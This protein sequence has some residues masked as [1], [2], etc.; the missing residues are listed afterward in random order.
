MIARK[1]PPSFILVDKATGE[2]VYTKRATGVGSEAIS[3]CVER[4]RALA[5]QTGRIYFV[6]LDIMGAR[7]GMKISVPMAYSLGITEEVGPYKGRTM[8]SGIKCCS[9]PDVGPSGQGMQCYNCRRWEADNYLKNPGRIRTNVFACYHCGKQIRGKVVHSSDGRYAFHGNCYMISERKAGRELH[10]KVRRNVYTFNNPVSGPADPTAARE[11]ELYI[12]NDSQLYHS[13]FVPIV[14]NLMLK[15]R[16]GVYNRELAAKLFMYLMDAGAKKYVREFGTGGKIDTMFNKNTRM[17]AARA[18]R[19]SFETEAELGNYDRMIG[20]VS[21]PRGRVRKNIY[22]FNNP[23]KY[24]KYGQRSQMERAAG[25]V[26]LYVTTWAPGDGMTRYRFHRKPADY[27][28]G[29]GIYTANGRGEAM[30]FIQSYGIGRSR[31]N[32]LNQSEIEQMR[33]REKFYIGRSQKYERDGQTADAAHFR[34]AS[35]ESRNIRERH[36]AKGTDWWPNPCKNPVCKNPKHKHVRKNPLLQ[37]I[38]LANPGSVKTFTE[39]QDVG[40][41]KYVVNYHDGVKSHRDGS[42]FFDIAIFSNRTKKDRFVRKLESLGF[43]RGSFRNPPISAQWDR[44]TGRQRLM[45]LDFVGFDETASRYVRLPWKLLSSMVKQ[46]L[47]QYWLNSTSTRG[48]TRRRMATAGTNPLTR[49]EAGR[50]I[51]SAR[52]SIKFG[53]H[54]QAGHT[55]SSMAG[56]AF[57]KSQVVSQFGPKSARPAARKITERAQRMAGTVISNPGG[58]RLPRPGTRMT[59][60]AALELARRIGDRGLIEQCQKALKLQK[61]ANKDAK[62]VIWKTFA[63]GSKDKIDS[64]VALTHYGD[65]PETMYK[66]PKGSK[67]GNHM[68]RHTWG[69]KGGKKSVPLLASAD[70]KMLLMPL[71]GRKVAGDWLRH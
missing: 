18:F 7:V 65:S 13:Q 23:K 44:L 19:D 69:E 70:G 14:K 21:N 56:K 61:A 40:K 46:A 17:A 54:F 43:T 64:V 39:T 68:Y 36:H 52:T 58:L 35:Q 31:M 11:L 27:H 12:D 15:R 62:C 9:T 34:G 33:D 38:L 6:Y 71:E 67:K 10:G 53:E 3:K 22:T 57:G 63:M 42:P 24:S 37:T 8:P 5:A 50:I 16:K 51:K 49:R 55:R 28:D 26:G 66:P 20:P 25:L 2:V 4:G 60:S 45:L 30:K 41:A 1:N 29:S 59:V 32:P 47:E 48:T